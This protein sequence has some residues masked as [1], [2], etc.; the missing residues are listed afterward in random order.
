MKIIALICG[1]IFLFSPYVYAQESAPFT[2]KST[3]RLLVINTE[4]QR[5]ERYL[6]SSDSEEVRKRSFYKEN[7][8]LSFEGSVYHPN[9]MNFNLDAQFGLSQQKEESGIGKSFDTASLGNLR[10]VTNWLAKKPYAFSLF[11]DKRNFT[12]NYEFFERVK[13]E[14]TAVGGR[15]RWENKIVPIYYSLEKSDT[16]ERKTTRPSE[17]RELI[18][19]FGGNKTSAKGNSDTRLDYTYS[20]SERSTPGIYEE[21]GRTHNLR[22][23]NNLIFGKKEEKRLSSYIYYLTLGGTQDMDSINLSE[24]LELKHSPNLSSRYSYDLNR[25]SDRGLKTTTQ[26]G[27]FQI[28]HQLYESLTT[29]FNM[30]GYLTRATDY[31]EDSFGPGINLLY[32]K[33]IKVGFL[34]LNYNLTNDFKERR[35]FSQT[36][37][38]FDESQTL[39]DGVVTLL[40]NP[41]VDTGS[42][43]V[44]DSGGTTRYVLNSD[45]TVSTVGNR[46]Q[47]SRIATG[48]I[49]NGSTVLV[50]YTTSTNPSFDYV[51]LRQGAGIRTDFLEGKLGLYYRLMS[52]RYPYSEKV[53]NMVLETTKGKIVGASFN[54]RP[55]YGSVEHEKYESSISPY[56]AY[57]V[58]QSFFL[59]LARR[60]TLSFQSSQSFTRFQN[61]GEKQ[62]FYDFMTRYRTP[63]S[64]FT[65][66]NME[67]GYRRQKGANI[68]LTLQT[69]RTYIEF[70]RG[71]LS[72]KIGYEFEDKDSW[73]DLRRDH[74]IYTEWRREF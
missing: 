51:S 58:R 52:Q 29:T 10:W 44:T 30:H 4:N 31:D 40:N 59:T 55:F 32:R 49:A 64:S 3:R 16:R 9:L 1:I 41:D 15:G 20:K 8:E 34:T 68:N 39:T 73:G 36:I 37:L 60:S 5:T 74:Y 66:F 26:R 70:Q 14:R 23:S 6:P 19:N 48:S 18:F 53:E 71:F 27:R 17:E 46:I 62:R 43:E 33:N 65:F 22:L 69:I 72:F 35:A 54:F 24:G 13:T 7:L 42:I 56:E 38:V 2:I 57:R 67:G 12:R 25:V 63:L 28:R 47:L 45:Y 50:D 21:K 11:V 61:T